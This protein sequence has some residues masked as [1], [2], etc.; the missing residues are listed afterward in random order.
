M[1][2][3]NKREL[4]WPRKTSVWPSPTIWND[5]Q[6]SP[7]PCSSSVPGCRATI[8]ADESTQHACS[9]RPRPSSNWPGKGRRSTRT[10]V[11]ARWTSS[12][13][14]APSRRPSCAPMLSRGARLRANAILEVH[15][16][17]GGTESQ[18][19]AGDADAHVHAAGPS[20]KD[21]SSRP[22]T[23]RRV[24]E[25]GIKS[26]D[27]W[28]INGAP[29]P[30]ATCGSSGESTGW[31]VS[32]LSTQQAQASHLLRLGRRDPRDRMT[33]FDDRDRR[34]AT[35]RIDTYRSSGRRRPA[36]QQVTDSAVRITHL[37]TNIGGELPERALP[38]PEQARWR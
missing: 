1:S 13:E 22:W 2:K 36:R 31:C 8:D 23:T 4:D 14:R 15:P 12:L 17:A 20:G 32:R 37:P 6:I 24:E 10:C 30:T 27:A 28:Q 29:T 26:V 34:Q 9:R 21:S 7:R 38:A 11:R 5:P 16:G 3:A 33:T 25:A 18:D 35:L 19:W